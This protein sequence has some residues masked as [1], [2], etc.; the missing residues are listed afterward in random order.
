RQVPPEALPGEVEAF[1]E[2]GDPPVVVTFGS[3]AAPGPVALVTAVVNGIRHAG[4]RAIVQDG[5]KGSE[6]S[7]GVLRIG[8]VDH[9]ALFPR[10]AAIVHH[11]GAGTTHAAVAAGRPSVVVPHVGD[12]P[13]WADRLHRLG[14]APAPVKITQLT[15]EAV[16]GRIG[17]ATTASIRA[18]ATDLGARVAGERGV[19]IAVD[20]LEQAA[21]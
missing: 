13:F 3:M 11:G 19:Q 5:S 15:A 1:L 21:R 16:A 4:H 18:A 14:V 9:R 17:Q 20:L 7:E 10:A 2:A 8:G 6:A 12:Q